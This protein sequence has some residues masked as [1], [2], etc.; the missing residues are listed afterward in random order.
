M[1]WRC[2]WC[3]KPHEE[4]DPPCDNCGHGQFEKA[5][6]RRTDLAE[7][8]EREATLVWV[9]TDCGRE[10][11]KHAPPC[12]RCGNTTLEKQ[13]QHV[14]EGE[15]TAPGYLDLATPRYLAAV[16]LTL[17]VAAV[18]VLG[19]V[20]VL[21]L[22]GFDRGGV[23][24]VDGVP[25]NSTAAGEIDLG[26]VEEA[27]VTALNDRLASD[28][29]QRL[30]RSSSLDEIATYD[31]QQ[32]LKWVVADG[33]PRDE[34]QV[35]DLLWNQ[36]SEIDSGQFQTTAVVALD[37]ESEP[38]QLA[39]SFVTQVVDSESFEPP[40]SADIVGVDVHNIDGQLYLRQFV[41]TR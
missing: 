16:G 34:E 22:P 31:N 3:G 19:F 6:V 28:G 18:F 38:Q 41:C 11:P 40:E 32:V 17:A 10:H 27:Y 14:D 30:E 7:E 20:G 37:N 33:P 4:N 26:T 29:H 1:E 12:S 35:V 23:P 39:E 9:C 5:I 24:D 25:G 13:R 21:D 8:A 36:C 15:L 2:K